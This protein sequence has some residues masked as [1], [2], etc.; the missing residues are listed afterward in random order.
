MMKASIPLLEP[1]NLPL[2][3]MDEGAWDTLQDNLLELS[4]VK[5]EQASKDIFT[6]EFLE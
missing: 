1:E 5:E 4:F 3:K 6:N 2:G